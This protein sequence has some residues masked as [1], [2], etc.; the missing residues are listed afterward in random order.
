[1]Q[2][3]LTVD[4]SLKVKR[5]YSNLEKARQLPRENKFKKTANVL[6]DNLRRMNS[7][8]NS[9]EEHLKELVVNTAEATECREDNFTKVPNFNFNK[10]NADIRCGR[11]S[12]TAK[13]I[14][15]KDPT[16]RTEEEARQLCNLVRNYR[17]I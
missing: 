1:M 13:S 10:F 14:L 5:S 2:T 6:I 12:E 8:M 11:I 3:N 16:K 9:A 15:K 17:K 4:D 7:L